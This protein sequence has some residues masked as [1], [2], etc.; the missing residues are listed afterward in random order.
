MAVDGVTK[1]PCVE[2][3]PSSSSDADG[4]TGL[5]ACS[6]ASRALRAARALVAVERRATHWS[7]CDIGG[8]IWVERRLWVERS[9]GRY[10][11]PLPMGHTATGHP[12]PS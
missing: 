11:S 10:T 8:V 6:V 9:V 5:S 1:V 12:A 4:T 2:E 3:R 7:A